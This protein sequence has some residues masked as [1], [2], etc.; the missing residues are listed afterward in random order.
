MSAGPPLQR[1]VPGGIEL[2]SPPPQVPPRPR[3][4]LRSEGPAWR[5]GQ[6]SQEGRTP[7]G[8]MSSQRCRRHRSESSVIRLPPP[9]QDGP[10]GVPGHLRLLIS[11][12][13]AYHHPSYRPLRT[14]RGSL[15][16][17]QGEGRTPPTHLG[18]LRGVSFVK[19]RKVFPPPGIGGS[20]PRL[21][22]FRVTAH[23]RES[24]VGRPSKPL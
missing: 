13:G 1:V 15:E 10:L 21:S 6:T 19:G 3:V 17:R 20:T 24:L 5:S 14:P 7:K 22:R 2:P 8:R 23:L 4:A 18:P 12:P 16:P 11:S 9:W